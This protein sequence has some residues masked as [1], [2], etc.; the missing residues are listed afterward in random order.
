MSAQNGVSDSSSIRMVDQ[1]P[2]P[3]QD[4]LTD[5]PSSQQTE[6]GHNVNGSNALTAKSQSHLPASH[7]IISRAPQIP[8][9]S[10]ATVELLAL[11]NGETRLGDIRGEHVQGSSVRSPTTQATAENL[12]MCTR[13]PGSMKASSAIIDLPSV[14]FVDAN[15]PL[16]TSSLAPKIAPLQPNSGFVTIAP[17][18]TDAETIS[19]QPVAAAPLVTP[20]TPGSSARQTKPTTVPRQRRNKGSSKRIRKRRRAEDSDND[21]KADSSSSDES[22]DFTPTATQ[23]KSGRQVHKPSLFV[24]SPVPG[25][26]VKAKGNSPDTSARLATSTQPVRKRRRVYRKGKEPSVNCLRC[27]RGHSPSVNMIVFC[28]ECNRAWHQ[29]CHDPPIEKD[30]IAVKE[31]E[32]F[33]AQCRPVEPQIDAANSSFLTLQN[34]QNLAV[35]SESQVGGEHFSFEEK[36]SYLFTLPHAALVNLLLNISERS[37]TLPIFPLN[38]KELLQRPKAFSSATSIIHQPAAQHGLNQPTNRVVTEKANPPLAP[39][40]NGVPRNSRRKNHSDE[41]PD[42]S[43]SEYEFEEHR[44]YPRPGNGFC[45]P[46]EIEDL[47]MLLEDPACPTYSYTLHA[48]AKVPMETKMRIHVSG[49]A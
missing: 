41:S 33:C 12:N 28:D 17:K 14:P 16:A 47:D 4:L 1:A 39:S 22:S 5:N 42:S 27:Q 11:V 21:F 38:L 7:N 48:F 2:T 23:T 34:V 29:F 19:S 37:P 20:S 10:A 13:M 46:S 40:A 44:L 45:L 31:T 18:P 26:A 9:L 36:R 25:T 32:W 43:G 15:L 3:N 8:E 30:I 49:L 6:T 24:P 35:V